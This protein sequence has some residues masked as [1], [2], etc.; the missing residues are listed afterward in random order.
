MSAG[1]ISKALVHKVRDLLNDHDN[2]LIPNDK[3]IYSIMSTLQ[4]EWM[5]KYKTTKQ[6]F[7]ITLISA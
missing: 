4:R 7:D 1:D 5:I 6:I 3:I 2:K